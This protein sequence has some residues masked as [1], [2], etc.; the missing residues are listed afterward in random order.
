[1]SASEWLSDTAWAA[2]EPHLPKNRPSAHR[3]EIA[4]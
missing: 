1:M 2:L 4:E 3:T